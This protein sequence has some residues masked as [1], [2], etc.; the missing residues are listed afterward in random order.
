[1]PGA[2][3]AGVLTGHHA[4][5]LG[6]SGDGESVGCGCQGQ[7]RGQCAA[8]PGPVEVDATDAGRSDLGCGGRAS[9]V[10]SGRKP[11]ST[12]SSDAMRPHTAALAEASQ[13]RQGLLDLARGAAEPVC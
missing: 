10:W 9:R 4:D 1:M 7:D 12:Q 13:A 5:L 8:H 6:E 2:V 3:F 11:M